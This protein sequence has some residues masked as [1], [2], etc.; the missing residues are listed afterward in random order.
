[1]N[2]TEEHPDLVCPSCMWEGDEDDAVVC[3]KCSDRLL[4]YSV[5]A[6]EQAANNRDEELEE[7]RNNH[8]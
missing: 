7:E 6:E 1:M 8:E 3:P 2:D 5:W 4:D